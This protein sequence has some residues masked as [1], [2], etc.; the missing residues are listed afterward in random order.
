MFD[1][2][3]HALSRLKA[4]G[5]DPSSGEL[6]PRR[7]GRGLAPMEGHASRVLIAP[8]FLDGDGSLSDR[9]C[10][11]IDISHDQLLV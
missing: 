7:E 11:M 9:T 5:L 4:G 6:H 10:F 2:D 8:G 3:T 1:G